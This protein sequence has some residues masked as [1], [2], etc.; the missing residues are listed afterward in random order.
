MNLPLNALA[1]AVL[2]AAALSAPAGAS[3]LEGP[4]RFCGYSPII[5]LLPGEKIT[6]L[7]G[8][9]HGGAFRWE[10]AFGSLDVWGIGW[11]ARPSG[12]VVH[13][14]GKTSPARFAQQRVDD[15]YQ[16]AIWNGGHGA[17][18]FR[19]P[20]PLT[21]AQRRAIARVGLFEE[22]ETPEGCRLRTVFSWE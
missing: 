14:P 6:V 1:A 5:D 19:S 20:E 2:A 22:G 10:G 12:L 16:I 7:S 21:R 17:A 15:G 18:Y 13:K 4:G 8:G 11:A 9:I 3:D